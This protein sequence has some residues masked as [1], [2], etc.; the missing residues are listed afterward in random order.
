MN[1]VSIMILFVMIIS[2]SQPIEISRKSEIIVVE[3]QISNLLNRSFIQI[4]RLNEEGTRSNLSELQV[5]VFTENGDEYNFT[6]NNTS[7]L[8]LPA[9]GFQGE[10]GERYR[11]EATGPE[12]LFFE[13]SYDL[14]TEPVTF[15]LNTKDTVIAGLD[16]LNIINFRQGTAAIAEVPSQE[17]PIYTRMDFKYSYVDFFTEEVVEILKEGDFVLYD[18][19]TESECARATDVSVGSTTRN[20]WFFI[21]RTEACD[22]A[23]DTLNHIEN[24]DNNSCC[25]FFPDWPALFEIRVESMSKESYEFWKDVERLRQNNGLIFDTYPFPISGNVSCV[26]CDTDVVGVFR[27]ISESIEEKSVS[28]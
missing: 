7:S 2:C 3:G 27:S 14:M 18:C 24:C 25:Q 5:I 20:E 16:N 28:L 23:A 26:N 12:G 11:F 13:S 1:R 4:F 22:R 10:I 6:N 8:Y 21:S 19:D 15:N 9:A 17:N